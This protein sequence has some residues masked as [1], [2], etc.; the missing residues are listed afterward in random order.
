MN[1]RVLL[2]DVPIYC[3]SFSPD[4]RMI[5]AGSTDGA[6]YIRDTKT[7][8]PLSRGVTGRLSGHTGPV[9]GFCF[10]PSYADRGY[11]YALSCSLDKTVRTWDVKHN[12]KIY[13]PMK[14]S[15]GVRGMAISP[16]GSYLAC[17]LI[18]NV[19]YIWTLRPVRFRTPRI[20]RLAGPATAVAF[21]HQGNVVATGDAHGSMHIFDLDYQ[22]E[23]CIPSPYID[24]SKPISVKIDVITF[25]FD[26]QS[27]LCASSGPD[28]RI[29]PLQTKDSIPPFQT[30]PNK[31]PDLLLKGSEHLDRTK[32]IVIGENGFARVFT[33]GP[34]GV[35]GIWYPDT[36]GE[37][38]PSIEM[39][40]VPGVVAMSKDGRFMVS[41]RE[42]DRLVILWDI[43]PTGTPLTENEG[44]WY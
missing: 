7:M 12:V 35:A 44:W 3:L 38:L 19:L 13:Y 28:V 40:R 34:N 21:S 27:I 43:P 11:Q 30:Y 17:I 10:D 37:W 1:A 5:A 2:D 32:S 23:R 25:T 41:S 6:I 15:A 26:G 9:T 4:S 39:G 24:Y 14:H 31:M 22:T 36:G 8:K 42:M 16:D 20:F 18:T 33:V 29:V